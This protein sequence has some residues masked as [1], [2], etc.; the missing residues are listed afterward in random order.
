M[1]TIQETRFHV[2]IGDRD[3]PIT[4]SRVVV[5]PQRVWKGK[6]GT[7]ITLLTGVTNCDYS[8]EPGGT[9]LIYVEKSVQ[10]EELTATICK[11]TKRYRDAAADRKELGPGELVRKR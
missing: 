2:R 3:E 4:A 5:K 9:Y 1:L 8:F 7:S 6:P 10:P 11:P